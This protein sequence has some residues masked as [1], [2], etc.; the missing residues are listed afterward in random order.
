MIR[1]SELLG[2]RLEDEAGK[3]LG[4]V[5]DLRFSGVTALRATF[6]LYGKKSVLERLGVWKR[7]VEKIPMERVA[8]I[9][10]R[11]IKLRG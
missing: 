9:R 6:I 5:V 7:P 2:M 4:H 10:G 11:T 3:P 1:F 8:G